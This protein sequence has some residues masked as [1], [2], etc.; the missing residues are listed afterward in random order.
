MCRFVVIQMYCISYGE[1]DYKHLL[2]S[3]IRKI[4][5]CHKVSAAGVISL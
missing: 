5:F 4:A 1:S 3:T 2:I